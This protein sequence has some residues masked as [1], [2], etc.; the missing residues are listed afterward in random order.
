[1][2]LLIAASLALLVIY[3]GVKLLIQTKKESLGNLYRAASWFF[4]IAGFLTL[5]CTGACCI[6]LC[7]KY[8]AKMMHKQHKMMGYGEDYQM[9]DH[10]KG[11][12]YMMKRHWDSRD[13]S[14][15]IIINCCGN[16]IEKCCDYRDICKPDTMNYNQK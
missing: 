5:A 4:I 9:K 3:A 2:I 6:A 16:G 7:C 15:K 13:G 10:H 14:D 11:Y 1:M 8:G 12:K